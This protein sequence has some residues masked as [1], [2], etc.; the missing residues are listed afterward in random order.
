LEFARILVREIT[1]KFPQ[2][3]L[4][5]ALFI[6]RWDEE[7]KAGLNHGDSLAE[8]GGEEKIQERDQNPKLQI[9]NPKQIPNLKFQMGD[10]LT[11]TRS[12]F[13]FGVPLA[14]RFFLESGVRR[15]ELGFSSWDLFGIWDL[16]FGIY[17]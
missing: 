17:A 6:V 10:G 4:D 1:A 16:E 5:A 12:G 9:P 14:S 2:Y 7:Q 15:L 11:I 13:V 3:R 8:N